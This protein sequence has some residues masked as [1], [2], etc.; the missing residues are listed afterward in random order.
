MEIKFIPTSYEKLTPFV[1]GYKQSLSSP[2]DS[3]LEDHILGSEFYLLEFDGKEAGYTAI[4]KSDLLTQFYMREGA[5]RH[6]Q[7]AFKQ[8][9]ASFPIKSAFVPTCDELFL[10]LAM[11]FHKKV[12]MQAYFFMDDRMTKVAPPY[13]K[14]KLELATVR[15][16]DDILKM[17][18]D[19]FDKLDERIRNKQI[20]TFRDGKDLLGAGIIEMGK[21]LKQ[22]G[23]IGMIVNEKFRM[24]GIG[25][26]IIVHLK[27]WCYDRGIIPISGCWYQNTN[28][29]K[30]LERAGMFTKT[31]LLNVKF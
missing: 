4:F 15:D 29:K 6:A 12:E 10:S 23:S 28:S 19:F 27:A 5:L 16:H 8:A 20:F 3:F 22:Y 17:S 18:G 1:E 11:D 2:I 26:S 13:A 21:M 31:R 7:P 9:L 24:M 30:T 25:T 14:G